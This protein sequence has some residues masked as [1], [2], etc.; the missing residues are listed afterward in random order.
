MSIDR[1]ASTAAGVDE[2]VV[3]SRFACVVGGNTQNSHDLQGLP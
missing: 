2:G 3:N 1:G